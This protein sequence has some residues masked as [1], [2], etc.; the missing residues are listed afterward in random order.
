MPVSKQVYYPISLIEVMIPKD[1][2]AGEAKSRILQMLK[3]NPN[4]LFATFGETYPDI[5]VL[6]VTANDETD[7]LWFATETESAKIAQLRNN[8]KAVIYAY[9]AE[10][11]S[12]FRLFGSVELLN[13][14]AA[15]QKVWQDD[16]VEHWPDGI[17]SPAM[18]VLRFNTDNGVYSNYEEIGHFC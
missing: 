7:V 5:R 11:M 6:V 4:V 9:D 15:R 16:F 18:T 10:P 8:P 13:D 17:D 1:I 14:S 3:K 2:S 12:E